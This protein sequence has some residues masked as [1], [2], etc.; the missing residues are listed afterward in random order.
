MEMIKDFIQPELLSLIP[1]LYIIGAAVKKSA[2]E[3]KY[4]PYILGA[5]GIVLALAYVLATSALDT[6][7]AAVIAVFTGIVQG[8]LTAGASVYANQLVKQPKKDDKS[9]KEGI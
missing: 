6:W 7:Q 4:I 3:D 5:V 2:A 8:V 9:T 1:V